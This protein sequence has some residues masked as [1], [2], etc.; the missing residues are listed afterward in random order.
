MEKEPIIGIDLGT[1]TSSVA[2][3]EGGVPTIIPNRAGSPKIPSIAAIDSGGRALTGEDARHQQ[4]A[5]PGGTIHGAKRLM[6]RRWDFRPEGWH[7]FGD[8]RLVE[9][10]RR[11]IRVALRGEPYSLPEIGSMILSALRA[12]AEQHLGAE[13][14][15]CV[16]AVP[17]SFNEGQRQA[18][19]DAG[20]VAGLEVLGLINDPT[21]V[22]VALT[23]DRAA[24][25]RMA[26][27][28][29]GGGTFDL[30]VVEVVGGV[31]DVLTAGGDPTLGG[32]DFDCRIAEWLR[33]GV[34][35]EHGVDLLEEP[36]A[37]QRVRRASEKAKIELSASIL[38]EIHLPH[39]S[40]S[41]TSGPLHVRR[42][43]SREKYQELTADLCLRC[44]AICERTLKEAGLRP[45][46][47]QEVFVLGGQTQDP[48]LQSMF[49]E[50]FGEHATECPSMEEVVARGAAI[51]GA[52]LVDQRAAPLFS[53]V[54]PYA[55]GMQVVGGRYQTILEENTN[56]PF[57]AGHV[58]TTTDDRQTSLRVTVLQGDSLRPEENQLIGEFEVRDLREEPRGELEI[59]LS[60]E[61]SADGIVAV[62]AKD[63]KTG[64]PQ[65]IEVKYTHALSE[66]EI[67]SMARRAASGTRSI[68]RTNLQQDF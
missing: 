38:S 25:G 50:Y 37:R 43:L 59:L 34:K 44:I 24:K 9:G 6:G 5:N 8:G 15:K 68:P 52:T 23:N 10:P 28:D 48:R 11:D 21:A 67:H 20:R 42:A 56:I 54:T 60:F 36:S 1:T 12:S 29:L 65:V 3:V 14:R 58:V 18:T 45:E 19:K 2:I 7:P 64:L 63:L 31:I 30:S 57:D 27:V 51:Y 4:A 49:R 13:V 53:D 62:S 16:I 39:V 61:I 41:K 66:A 26:V 17:A 33:L 40:S 35:D 55:L 47:L 46:H 22:A 32:E